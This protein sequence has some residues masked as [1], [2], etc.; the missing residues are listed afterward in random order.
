V[1]RSAGPAVTR[2]SDVTRENPI[3]RPS[4]FFFTGAARAPSALAGMS[5]AQG[6]A[7]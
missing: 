7:G 4:G 2:Q 3:F 5:V 6:P 1:I